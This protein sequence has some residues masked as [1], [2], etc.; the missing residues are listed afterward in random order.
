MAS[1][2]NNTKYP[3]AAGRPT[4]GLRRLQMAWEETG[5]RPA[6][7]QR[8][9]CPRGKLGWVPNLRGYAGDS[10]TTNPQE[11]THE[12]YSR[13]ARSCLL[14][15]L[16][17]HGPAAGA[18][19]SNGMR[20]S[21]AHRG[22]T[23]GSSPVLESLAY[24][25]IRSPSA[26]NFGQAG[27]PAADRRGRNGV[28][29]RFARRLRAPSRTRHFQLA[30]PNL[31]RAAFDSDTGFLREL[32]RR[33]GRGGSGHGRSHIDAGSAARVWPGRV[34]HTLPAHIGTKLFARGFATRCTLDVGATVR[35]WAATGRKPLA[36]RS[37]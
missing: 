21:S 12:T 29:E 32:M 16:A 10:P 31:A 7:A 18:T 9:R 6:A 13:P 5:P 27:E 22:D 4:T 11:G 23:A 15:R 19:R 17:W 34:G 26:L 37:L 2:R 24:S 28:A 25:A 8:T 30:P 1:R 3:A 14:G 20:D 36:Y 33:C 35:R